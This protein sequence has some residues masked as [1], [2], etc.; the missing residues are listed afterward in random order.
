MYYTRLNFNPICLRIPFIGIFF[1]LISKENTFFNI[2]LTL[3]PI[4]KLYPE[5][6]EYVWTD[7][8]ICSNPFYYVRVKKDNTETVMFARRALLWI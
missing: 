5:L 4:L 3:E 1:I 2:G 7:P 8:Y 6:N